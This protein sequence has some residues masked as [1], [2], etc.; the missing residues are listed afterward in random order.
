YINAWQ[1]MPN[2]GDLYIQTENIILDENFTGPFNVKDGRYVRISITDTGIGIEKEIQPRIFD[3]FFTT[4]EIGNGAGLGLASVYGIIKNHRGII[5]VYSEEGKG[6]TFN[7]YLP[8]SGK[9][10]V[11]EP[12][13]SETVLNGSE[14]ILLVDDEDMIVEVGKQMLEAMGYGVLTAT[15]GKGAV[16]A[17]RKNRERIRLV[18]LDMIIPGSNGRETYDRLKG[19]NSDIKVL[20]SSGYSINGEA[21]EIL[22]RGCNGFI[23]KPYSIKKLS[24]KVREILDS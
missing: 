14:T 3:P 4:K 12:K 11:V 20:L 19:I 7:I 24:Q 18:I 6:T 9:E 2:G 15:S 17:Y 5:N 22:D 1:A 13:I 10:V 16:G 8:A 21:T 23:Q